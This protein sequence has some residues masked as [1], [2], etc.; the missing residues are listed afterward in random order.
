MTTIGYIVGSLSS[1]SITRSVFRAVAQ[2]APEG[3]E[4]R[5]IEIKDLPVYSPDHDAAF[6]AAALAFKDAIASADAVVLGTPTYNDSF[7]GAV[8]NAVDWSSRPWG[9]HSFGA[10]P[11]AVVG[12]SVAPHGGAKAADMLAAVLE[13]GE[14]KV[15]ENRLNVFVGEETF[16]ADGNFVDADLRAQAQALIASLV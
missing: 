10:K 12:S 3:V 11:V 5:E 15:S 2:N 4:V 14:A 16:D 8:K 13:F 9:Q 6:P 7:S 1:S